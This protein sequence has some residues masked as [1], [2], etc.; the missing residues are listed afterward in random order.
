MD[1][2]KAFSDTAAAVTSAVTPDPVAAAQKKVDDLETQVST[3]KQ[4]LAVAQSAAKPSS[5]TADVDGVK[6]GGRRK[7]T[8]RRGKKSKKS[9]RSR[10]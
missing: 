5:G 9:R 6:T 2:S 3:A 4:E 1:I 7:K 8:R 10:K